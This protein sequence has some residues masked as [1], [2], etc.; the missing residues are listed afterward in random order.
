MPSSYLTRSGLE[1]LQTELDFLRNVKRQEIAAI[2]RESTAGNEIDGDM[3]TEFA[4]AKFQQS[5]I[6]GRIQE[7]ESLLSDPDIIDQ[8]LHGDIVEI[9]SRVKIE[10]NNEAPLTYT[11]VGPAE[12][13]PANGMISFASP[14]GSALIGHSAG[15][16]IIVK[17]PGGVYQVRILEVS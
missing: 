3:D 15:D 16:E 9:G 1:K 12:A 6:E 8:H 17:A 10:E 13:S 5:F 14:L 4:M 11:I 7:L 2:L